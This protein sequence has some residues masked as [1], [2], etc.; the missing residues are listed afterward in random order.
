[1]NPLVLIAA[2]LLS[3]AVDAAKLDGEARAE[4]ERVALILA[5]RAIAVEQARAELPK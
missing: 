3:A 4:A 5:A 1:M 2:E